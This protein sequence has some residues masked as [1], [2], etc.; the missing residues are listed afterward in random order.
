MD[1]LII[2]T[3][4][5]TYYTLYLSIPRLI[6]ESLAVTQA[7]ANQTGLQTN[8]NIRWQHHQQQQQQTITTAY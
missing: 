3:D 5:G 8:H 6:Y 1:E 4:H 7:P 2:T